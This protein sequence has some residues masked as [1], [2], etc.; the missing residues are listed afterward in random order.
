M[1]DGKPR[2]PKRSEPSLAPAHS[3][4][5][6]PTSNAANPESV[7]LQ[8]TGRPSRQGREFLLHLGTT[9]GLP[10]ETLFGDGHPLFFSSVHRRG[11]TL[12]SDRIRS[13]FAPL[14]ML[15]IAPTPSSRLPPAPPVHPL[16]N[17]TYTIA[18]PVI[19]VSPA[20]HS[21]SSTSTRSRHPVP[22]LTSCLRHPRAHP[23]HTR[24][25]DARALSRPVASHRPH[26]CR[27]PSGAVEL[28]CMLSPRDAPSPEHPRAHDDRPAKRMFPSCGGMQASIAY[29]VDPCWPV[30]NPPARLT[31]RS[32]CT[33]PTPCWRGG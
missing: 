16:S 2:R 15:P 9:I 5:A 12:D 23:S 24:H 4:P 19:F 22:L 26:A 6:L 31:A 10:L 29:S 20:R 14:H 17:V 27:Q 13:S 1:S 30:V 18:T 32:S 11:G 3:T 8:P 21:V 7:D 28:T 25:T 33:F